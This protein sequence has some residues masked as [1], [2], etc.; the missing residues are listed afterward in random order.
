[1][2]LHIYPFPNYYILVIFSNKVK[3]TKKKLLMIQ[4]NNIKP[5]QPGSEGIVVEE[6][7]FL[8]Q[9]TSD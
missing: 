2:N 6:F 9:S 7:I 1:M 3:K 8:R 4:D 5:K